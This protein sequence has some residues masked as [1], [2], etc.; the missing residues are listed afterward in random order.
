MSVRFTVL[1]L[2]T[3]MWASTLYV[4]KKKVFSSEI[5]IDG[6]MLPINASA[7]Q[8]CYEVILRRMH[9]Q[10]QAM[11]SHHC[12]VLV[13]MVIFHSTDYSSTNLL[14]SRLARK[15]KKKLTAKQGLKRVGYVWVRERD[16]RDAQHYHLALF[17]DGNRVQKPHTV[18]TLCSEI[19]EGWNQPRPSFPQGRSFY[20][21]R[22]GDDSVYR[23]AFRHLSYLA[24]V[25]TK[26]DR[27]SS[28][29]D[30]Y[31]SQIVPRAE[32]RPF[33]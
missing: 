25:R 33:E 18:F 13:F 10:I 24:K 32:S 6:V 1:R 15:L 30:Y 9:E 8:G 2:P 16:E 21:L 23:E 5:V 19:W 4:V 28:T 14:F 20:I 26:G 22:R 12:K 27:P 11:L 3:R 7:R 29:N 17:L 31:T